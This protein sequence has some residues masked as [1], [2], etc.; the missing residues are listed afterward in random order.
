M[1]FLH[2]SRKLRV[3]ELLGLGLRGLFV[4]L[5][6]EEFL[7]KEVALG[8]FG[9]LVANG[10]ETVQLLR[11]DGE[12]GFLEHLNNLVGIDLVLLH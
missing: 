2:G 8:L 4:E 10:R 12:T 3:A 9:G 11:F 7:C 6:L 1:V 5:L